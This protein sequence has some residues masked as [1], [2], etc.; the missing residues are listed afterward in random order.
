MKRIL[1]IFFALTLL[2]LPACIE[3]PDIDVDAI[4]CRISSEGV[5]SPV[6]KSSLPK[7]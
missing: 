4:G 2:L 7:K 6:A 5:I 3:E 1:V